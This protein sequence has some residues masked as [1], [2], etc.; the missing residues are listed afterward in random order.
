MRLAVCH[1]KLKLWLRK[2][3]SAVAKVNI[4]LPENRVKMMLNKNELSFQKVAQISIREIRSVGILPDLKIKFLIN[5]AIHILQR[6]TSYFL[7]KLKIIAKQM[8]YMMKLLHSYS[9]N[10]ILSTGEKLRCCKVEFVEK[11]IMCPTS[12]R[13]PRHIHITYFLCSIRFATTKC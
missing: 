4:N 9:K 6:I 3:F 11:A 5:F 8:N 10:I 2:F 12:T 1:I 13:I 7:N